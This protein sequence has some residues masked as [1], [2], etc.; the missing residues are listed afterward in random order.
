MRV[1]LWIKQFKDKDLTDEDMY[2]D[3]H[4]WGGYFVCG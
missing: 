3:E 2:K 4:H 1:A